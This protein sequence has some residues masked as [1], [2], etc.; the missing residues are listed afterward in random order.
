M[1][2]LKHA[3]LL[4]TGVLTLSLA[5]AAHA[6]DT[7]FSRWQQ[8]ASATQARQPRWMVPAVAPFPTL[9]QVFRSDF[10]RQRTPTGVQN[11]NLGASRG[12]N[13]IPFARTEVA[14]L[15]PP[16][17]EHGD[18]TRDGFGDLSFSAK[19]RFASGNELHGNYAAALSLVATVPTG[20][21]KNGSADAGLNPYLAFGKGFRK[22]D[23][24]SGIGG[25][26]PTGDTKALGRTVVTNS[27]A[28]YH[29]A[30]YFWPELE[31]NTTAWYGSSRDGK[32]Q[33]LLTPGL[34]TGKYA[35]RPHDETS[36][37]GAVLGIAFQT[38]VTH[39]HTFNH[40]LVF[41]GRILF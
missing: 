28:Q 3:A 38:A 41:S 5:A 19:Y 18:K 29:V 30:K 22:V 37:T 2:Q 8:R 7:F 13:V 10:T 15:V 24:V 6:Q 40:N 12:L 9:I 36:R 31:L 17:F 4:C 21:Y 33:S 11:W 26:L 34:M 16:F 14:V 25:T 1:P 35:F 23:F 27:Y 32:T 39:Y 20:S